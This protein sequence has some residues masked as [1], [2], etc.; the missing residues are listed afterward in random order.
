MEEHLKNY[1]MKL[2]VDNYARF[3]YY[4]ALED[5]T[6]KISFYDGRVSLLTK[7]FPNQLGTDSDIKALRTKAQAKVDEILEF[8]SE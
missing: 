6:G 7:A 8:M 5:K 3:L 4:K 1:V 2:Y